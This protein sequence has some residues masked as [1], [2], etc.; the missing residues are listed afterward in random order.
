VVSI[1]VVGADDETILFNAVSSGNFEEVKDLI[2]T[3]KINI[4]AEN[5]FGETPLHLSA[6]SNS[7]SKGQILRFLLQNSAEVN[8]QTGYQY[9]GHN[10]IVKRS[11]L[12]WYVYACDVVGV[13]ELLKYGADPLLLTEEKESSIDVVKKIIEAANRSGDPQGK[14]CLRVLNMMEEALNDANRAG[15]L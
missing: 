9:E 10:I 2:L 14:N 4:N 11:P 13:R 15:T 8:K 3:K 5:E 1:F 6:I 12:H 7:D